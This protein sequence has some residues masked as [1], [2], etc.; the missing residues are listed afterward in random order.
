MTPD[1][2]E[3]EVKHLRQAI[4]T[5][6]VVVALT[7]AIAATF[8]AGTLQ[9]NSPETW[10]DHASAVLMAFTIIVS[11]WLVTRP[12]PPHAEIDETAFDKVRDRARRTHCLVQ[13]QVV[14]SGLSCVAATMG[15]LLPCTWQ[16]HHWP[17]WH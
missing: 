5:A 13:V 12:V 17:S 8:V 11:F 16:P 2:R 4:G 15:L 10:W 6:K 14:L 1:A 3:R 7:A 9:V